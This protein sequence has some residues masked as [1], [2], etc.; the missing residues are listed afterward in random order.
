MPT[1]RCGLGRLKRRE[2]AEHDV[3]CVCVCLNLQTILV[4]DNGVGKTSLLVQ[5]D[6]GKFI[7]GS[8]TSTV[9]IGFTVKSTHTHNLPPFPLSVF[10]LLPVML[11][12]S[13]Q[14]EGHVTPLGCLYLSCDITARLSRSSL[15]RPW[16]SGALL[17]GMPLLFFFF[18][19][20]ALI[21]ILSSLEENYYGQ[22][23]QRC[24]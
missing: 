12:T 19:L 13:S 11:L 22:Q 3:S 4:G 10:F 16:I 6:Q 20:T 18:F 5:F 15:N 24:D 1:Q 7:P 9:G 23:S 2:A 21:T 14:W 17:S 8:F